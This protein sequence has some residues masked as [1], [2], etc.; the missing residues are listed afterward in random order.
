MKYAKKFTQ[1]LVCGKDITDRKGKHKT[2]QDHDATY[3]KTLRSNYNRKYYADHR[4]AISE[5]RKQI[6]LNV[7][8]QEQQLTKGD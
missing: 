3:K 7:A 2:C 1:C 8:N 4:T 5:R 6:R